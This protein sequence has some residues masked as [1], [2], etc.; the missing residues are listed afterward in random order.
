MSNAQPGA[1]VI[2]MAMKAQ[3]HLKYNSMVLQETSP[4]NG[5]TQINNIY[6]IENFNNYHFQIIN[7]GQSDKQMATDKKPAHRKDRKQAFMSISKEN[8]NKHRDSIDAFSPKPPYGSRPG[9]HNDQSN[10]PPQRG[11]N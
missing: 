7:P 6:S 9:N 10:S 8:V 4:T 1:N 11:F 2:Q 3:P 5:F